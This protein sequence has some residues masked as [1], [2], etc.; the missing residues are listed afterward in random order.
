MDEAQLIAAAVA[1]IT[2]PTWNLTKQF[3]RIHRVQQEDG[4]PVVA[5]VVF[6]PEDDTARVY[7][8]IEGERFYLVIYLTFLPTLGIKW[9]GTEEQNR[10]YFAAFSDTLSFKELASFTHLQPTDGWSKGDA[11]PHPSSSIP[12]KFT[13][14]DIEPTPTPDTFENKLTYLLDLL[15]KNVAGIKTLVERFKGGVQVATIF[16]NGNTMLGGF[17]LTNAH[18]R[19]LAALNL[20]IDFDLYAEGNFFND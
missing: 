14:L 19:R 5:G 8:A 6:T 12:Y 18:I 9:V 2:A 17:H 1:E 16:H 15:E 4:I 3:L 20:E 11:K 13:R 10:V 7:F